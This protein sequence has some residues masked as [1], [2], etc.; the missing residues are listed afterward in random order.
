LLIFARDLL[1]AKVFFLIERAYNLRL[2]LGTA[3]KFRPF[4]PNVRFEA[5]KPLL[6]QRSSVSYTLE[7]TDAPDTEDVEAMAWSGIPVDGGYNSQHDRLVRQIIGRRMCRL[8][9]STPLL[10]PALKSNSQAGGAIKKRKVREA[11]EKQ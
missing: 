4:G 5:L 8:A 9:V 7:E 2:E 10:K 11:G 1:P 6:S 3:S